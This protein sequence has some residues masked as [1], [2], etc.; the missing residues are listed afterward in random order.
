MYSK[1]FKSLKKNLTEV[2]RLFEIHREIGGSDPGRRHQRLEV[3][4]KSAIVLT[5]AYWEAFIEELCI[6]AATC[7]VKQ[8]KIKEPDKVPQSLRA[9]CLKCL[10][11]KEVGEF[12]K[13]AVSDWKKIVIQNAEFRAQGKRDGDYGFTT[14]SVEN[15]KDLFKHTLALE[16]VTQSWR[17]QGQRRKNAEEKLGQFIG[18]RSKIV[19][20]VSPRN[21]V[22]LQYAE[23]QRDFIRNLGAATDE[24]VKLHLFSITGKSPW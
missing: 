10:N 4:N 1:S 8:I 18:L 6:E 23:Q 3:I 19:H 2:D 22:H 24:N 15:I 7:L 16:D 20:G 9:S 13:V 11:I 14:P 12:W 17:W 21:S 5:C